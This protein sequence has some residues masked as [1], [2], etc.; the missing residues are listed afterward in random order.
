MISYYHHKLIF[1]LGL[2]VYSQEGHKKGKRFVPSPLSH[3]Q[4]SP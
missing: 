4:Q 3:S 1:L 2:K